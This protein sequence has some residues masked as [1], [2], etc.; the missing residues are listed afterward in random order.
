M[1]RKQTVDKDTELGEK[2]NKKYKNIAITTYDIKRVG[3]EDLSDN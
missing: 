1:E 2:R 3:K